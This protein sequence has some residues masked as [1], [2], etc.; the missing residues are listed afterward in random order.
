VPDLHR[1]TQS[2]YAEQ[3]NAGRSNENT[4]NTR[5]GIIQDSAWWVKPVLVGRFEFTE[6]TPDNHLRHSRFIALRDDKKP[7]DVVREG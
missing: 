5:C 2:D 3:N 4:R 6:W 7:K 1:N